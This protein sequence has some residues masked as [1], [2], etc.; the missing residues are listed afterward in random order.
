MME[1]KIIGYTNV[2]GKLYAILATTKSVSIEETQSK[3]TED[4]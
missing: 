2:Q 4:V 1:G 3:S